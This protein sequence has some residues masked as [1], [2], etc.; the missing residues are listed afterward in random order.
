[1]NGQTKAGLPVTAKTYLCDGGTGE[2]FDQ[3]ANRRV[4][5]YVEVGPTWLK[6]R[7]TLVLSVRTH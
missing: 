4:D 3:A 7:C 5:L 1:M 6:T 2:Q